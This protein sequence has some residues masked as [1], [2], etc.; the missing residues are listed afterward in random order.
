MGASGKRIAD[1]LVD[2]LF[3]RFLRK[4]CSSVLIFC[5]NRCNGVVVL[6]RITGFADVVAFLSSFVDDAVVG[7]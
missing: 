7:G 3:S 4:A 5:C 2:R 6:D 1:R